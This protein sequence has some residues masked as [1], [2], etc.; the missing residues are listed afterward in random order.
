MCC[1]AATASLFQFQLLSMWVEVDSKINGF[2]QQMHPVTPA[3]LPISLEYPSLETCN[4][5]RGIHGDPSE[6]GVVYGFSLKEVMTNHGILEGP[7]F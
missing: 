3:F 4:P 6:I 7:K 5:S 2:G 1:D